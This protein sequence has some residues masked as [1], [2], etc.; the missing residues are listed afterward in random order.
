L[1]YCERVYHRLVGIK[2]KGLVMAAGMCY[3]GIGMT[4]LINDLIEV[5]K[6]GPFYF[7]SAAI[8]VFFDVKSRR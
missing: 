5:D 4:N 6:I 7:M 1:F 8:I 2:E 3:F